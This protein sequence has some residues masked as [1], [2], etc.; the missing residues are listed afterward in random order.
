MSC[1]H[2]VAEKNYILMKEEAERK[3]LYVTMKLK[4]ELQAK[5]RL[6]CDIA[7]AERKN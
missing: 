3:N 5:S 2:A 7:A 6:E 1:D 4:Q